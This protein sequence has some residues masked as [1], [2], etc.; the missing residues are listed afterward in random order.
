MYDRDEVEEK[1]SPCAASNFLDKFRLEV[2]VFVEH[3]ERVRPQSLD[4]NA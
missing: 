4:E 3:A 2:S 1:L